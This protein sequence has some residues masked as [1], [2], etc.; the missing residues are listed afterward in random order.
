[1]KMKKAVILLAGLLCLT[2]FAGCSK[3]SGFDEKYAIK[4]VKL[5]DTNT[6]SADFMKGFS[7][8]GTIGDLVND[9]KV[10][11]VAMCYTT[12]DKKTVE[13]YFKKAPFDDKEGFL[14][15]IDSLD[16]DGKI[17]NLAEDR[18][19]Y[20]DGDT[21]NPI[22]F[23][24]DGVDL[25][26]GGSLLQNAGEY[27]FYLITI[28][29]EKVLYVQEADRTF[30]MDQG[31]IDLSNDF[32]KAF[33]VIVETTLM[34]GEDVSALSQEEKTKAVSDY[35][36]KAVDELGLGLITEVVY[37]DDE[38]YPEDYEVTVSKDGKSSMTYVTV[39]FGS[40]E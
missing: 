23:Y 35:F 10:F 4:D 39:H 19:S 18:K 26:N 36:S 11:S 37:G 14:S 20:L 12:S 34:E 2:A 7:L 3:K 1:M 17:R 30:T 31:S 25:I 38:S 8:Q 13:D 28:G 9:E 5:V 22:R 24:G 32:S 40:A 33:D 16:L 15:E 6:N 27:H 21:S 29:Y